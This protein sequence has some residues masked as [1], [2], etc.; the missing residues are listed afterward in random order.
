MNSHEKPQNIVEASQFKIAD[1]EKNPDQAREDLQQLILEV[2]KHIGR[3][4][5]NE[6]QVRIADVKMDA[7]T[8]I[9]NREFIEAKKDIER[10]LEVVNE[11]VRNVKEGVVEKTNGTQEQLD[12]L[13][14]NISELRSD[15][16]KNIEKMNGEMFDKIV[17]AINAADKS[18]TVNNLSNANSF[19][20]DAASWYQEAI[21]TYEAQ[22]TLTENK[23]ELSG[24]E[25]DATKP[26]TKYTEPEIQ[27]IPEPLVEIEGGEIESCK[28][29]GSYFS[30]EGTLADIGVFAHTATQALNEKLNRMN[31]PENNDL[32][33]KINTNIQ[34][35]FAY[36]QTLE[37]DYSKEGFTDEEVENLSN[38]VEKINNIADEINVTGPTKSS[39]GT[40]NDEE[41]IE[42]LPATE[43][44]PKRKKRF[45]DETPNTA[46]DKP[47]NK[48]REPQELPAE[49]E[50]IPVEIPPVPAKTRASEKPVE[51]PKVED[52]QPSAPAEKAPETQEETASAVRTK[53]IA[54]VN[55][56]E[57]LSKKVHKKSIS[58]ITDAPNELLL[59]TKKERVNQ[60]D[61]HRLDELLTKTK[62]IRDNLQILAQK[63]KQ[64]E[65]Q[66]GET[67]EHTT[68][69]EIAHT[70][71]ENLNPKDQPKTRKQ[72]LES[73][74]QKEIKNTETFDELF[75]SFKST[76]GIPN[77]FV[78]FSNTLNN[79]GQL[80]VEGLTFVINRVR[81]GEEDIAF[82]PIEYGIR[83]KV[84]ELLEKESVEVVKNIDENTEPLPP[85]HIVGIANESLEQKILM[86]KGSLTTETQA[87][88]Q[89]VIR[90]GERIKHLL[91]QE[92]GLTERDA[93]TAEQWAETRSAVVESIKK[94]INNG[95]QE[96][97]A[98]NL[99]FKTRRNKTTPTEERGGVE[100][101]KEIVDSFI[102]KIFGYK[103]LFNSRTE[104]NLDAWHYI[105]DIPAKNLNENP[106][107]LDKVPK[108][109]ARALIE[110]L[111]QLSE[112]NNLQLLGNETVEAFLIRAAQA[113]TGRLSST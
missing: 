23:R 14:T 102:K 16:E 80:G 84:L 78:D 59:L 66:V 64:Q 20:K 88:A 112:E 38:I 96:N 73:A 48:R 69:K 87:E 5:T 65:I 81:R 37:N 106:A 11:I 8:S 41:D 35:L 21:R 49:V 67:T 105:K 10:A 12:L 104:V 4:L 24:S 58:E 53:I 13:H 18:L 31:I 46:P 42:E 85:S 9:N 34:T 19:Y 86:S 109:Q 30:I 45:D 101:T 39:G 50:T 17:G 15:I 28:I 93:H 107:V 103:K 44:I 74:S 43:I 3:L 51:K 7:V 94:L 6:E 100:E 56:V 91:D 108:K 98:D 77:G 60:E 89:D 95:T 83:E 62:R 97:S 33:K 57:G 27:P 110:I 1:P 90:R 54:L 75:K 113:Q 68:L 76:H 99:V 63:P 32:R 79:N 70:K 61:G 71:P 29:S 82:V 55:E 52:T 111:S 2:E 36:I 92:G 40:T 22:Q 26:V 47:K 72:L 25:L